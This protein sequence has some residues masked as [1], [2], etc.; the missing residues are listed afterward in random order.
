MTTSSA[1]ASPPS[2]WNRNFL[3]WWLGSAQSAF[4][5]ALAGI[6]TSFL[7]LH[8]TDSAGAMG[9]NLALTLL[10]AL[11]QPLLGALVDRWPLRIPLVLGNL[12]RGLLQL[13][14]GW[15]AL[16]GEVP[17]AVIYTASFLTG[18]VGAFYTP[19]TQGMV[20][21][22]V[23]PEQIERGTGLMQGATQTMTMLGYVGGGVLVAALGRA[24]S[25]LLD[26]ASFLLFAGLLLLVQF[27]ARTPPGPGE[28]FWQTFCAGMNYMRG[29]PVLVGLPLLALLINAAFAPLEMLLPKRMLALGAGEQGFGLFFGLILAGMAGGSFAAA[30]LGK[31]VDAA[32]A[33]VWGMAGTGAALLCLALAQTPVQMYPLAALLG[34]AIAFTNFG[35]GII[36]QKRVQ[37]E[38]FGRVGS[39]LG[40]V[41][42]VGMPLTLLLLSPLADRIAVQ[43]I[44]AV[45]GGVTLLGTLAWAWLLRREG[46]AAQ[47]A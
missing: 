47:P 42:M 24:Q 10:P 40:T 20:A 46:A 18:L 41:S 31:R 38:Y 22:L 1:S 45:S 44:F 26:G 19:A 16:R 12:L 36:F 34:L 15:L 2:L 8:Q 32:A 28:T 13:G 5:T 33:S 25:I 29:R 27:P 7:V 21:R 3:L 30:A 11:L 4:G 37:P 43:T 23:P 17:L 35:I 9:V 6:A 14:V 39:L